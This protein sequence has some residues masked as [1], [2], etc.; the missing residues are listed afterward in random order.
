LTNEP[1]LPPGVIVEL[2]RRR[3]EAEKTF[4]EVKN[5]LGEKKAWA[6]SLV[7]KEAQALFIAITHNLLLLYE[8]RL[9]NQHGVTNQAED[10]RRAQRIKA[11]VV[12]CEKA[13]QSL[14]TLLTRARRAT[15]RSVKFIRWVRQ[16]I[17]DQ[18]AEALAVLRLMD[19]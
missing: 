10:Q 7:A 14:S 6:T 8:Q 17:R 18:A 2:Y 5:K 12:A 15:Q 11:A 9:E 3:W 13:G 16:A 4:D 19:L 1:D